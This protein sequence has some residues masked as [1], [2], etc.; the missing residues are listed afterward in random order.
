MPTLSQINQDFIKRLSGALGKSEAE[1]VFDLLVLHLTG[2]NKVELMVS[3]PLT[4]NEIQLNWMENAILRLLLQEPIQYI[5][6]YTHFLG[7]E[8][9]VNP[10]VLI[11]RPETEELATWVLQTENQFTKSV[12]D[13]CTGSGCIALTLQKLGNWQKVA[14]LD[15]SVSA[16]EVA[17]QNS[18]RLGLETRTSQF[19]S[20]EKALSKSISIQSISNPNRSEFCRATSSAE[21]L[22][23]RP[24][25]FCQFPNFCNASAMQLGSYKLKINL[26]NPFWT[27]A[28]AAVALH[29]RCKSWVTGKR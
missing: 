17:R 6:G 28:Q 11:P 16:L 27:Y 10:A 29:L 5:L 23:S 7:L 19:L 12:L 14:G 25:T 20:N 8:I 2:K 1:A 24:A 3:Q 18:E 13:L 26:I 4:L 15:I 21:S 9:V 22:T